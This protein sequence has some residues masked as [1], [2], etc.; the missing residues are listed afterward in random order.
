MGFHQPGANSSPS[1]LTSVGFVVVV[2]EFL[3]GVGRTVGGLPGGEGAA[4]ELVSGSWVHSPS[5]FS[6][7]PS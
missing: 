4:D 1:L 5:I 2:I 7:D 3:L 6:T